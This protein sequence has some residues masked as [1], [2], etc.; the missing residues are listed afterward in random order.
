VAWRNLPFNEIA[1]ERG[2]KVARQRLHGLPVC[3]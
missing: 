2:A 1:A 3:R